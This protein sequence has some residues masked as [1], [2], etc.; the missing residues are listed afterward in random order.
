M[1]FASCPVVSVMRLAARPVGAHSTT[2]PNSDKREIMHLMM[3]VLP[4]PGPPVITS[5]PRRSAIKM[6]SLW[7]WLNSI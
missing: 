4:V 2:S 7:R 1:V 5:K 6:A 3:V